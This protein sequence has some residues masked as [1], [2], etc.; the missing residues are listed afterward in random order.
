[1]AVT[2]DITNRKLAEVQLREL[3]Q[4]L[5]YHIGNSPLA[6]MGLKEICLLRGI[7]LT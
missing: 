4:R 3:T 6:V 2:L 5:S 7:E 1:V